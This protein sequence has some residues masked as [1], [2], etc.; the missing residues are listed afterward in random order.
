MQLLGKVLLFRKALFF[1]ESNQLSTSK[2]NVIKHGL[3][4]LEFYTQSSFPF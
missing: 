1:S 3:D 4:G 2:H